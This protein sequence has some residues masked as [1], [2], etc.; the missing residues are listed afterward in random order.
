MGAYRVEVDKAGCSHCGHGTQYRIVGPDDVMLSTTWDDK[1]FVDE[2][3]DE[4][5]DAY[6]KGMNGKAPE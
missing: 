5:N 1:T 4:L 2:F 6:A 3:V